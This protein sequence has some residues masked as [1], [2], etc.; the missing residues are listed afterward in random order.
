MDSLESNRIWHLVDLPP[1][2][3]AIGCKWVLWHEKFDNLIISHGF[4]VNE[5]DKCIY[6]KLKDNICTIVYLYVDD[7]LIFGSNIHVVNSVKQLLNAEFD[8]KDLGEANVILGIKITRTKSGISLDQCHYLEKIL[9]KYGYYEYKPTC[10]IFDPSA[11]LFQ[12][13]SDGVR[14]SDYASIIG[15]LR[16][17]T[18]LL[19]PM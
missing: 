6:V 3:K 5:S 4:R 11:K 2:C 7:F 18:V 15:S 16:Y 13:T 17:A 1:G 14:Q 9:K 19:D 12:N 10:T 8:M